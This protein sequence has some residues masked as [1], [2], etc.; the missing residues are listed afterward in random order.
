MFA[1]QFKVYDFKGKTVE[2]VHQEHPYCVN[3]KK[4]MN[5]L[6][7]ILHLGEAFLFW[8]E[9]IKSQATSYEENNVFLEY[10]DRSKPGSRRFG[11]VATMGAFMPLVW[12]FAKYRGSLWKVGAFY[13]FYRFMDAIYDQ[14]I[15][16]YFFLYGPGAMKKVLD[17]DGDKS[18]GH[19]QVKLFMKHCAKLELDKARGDMAKKHFSQ[20]VMI[21]SFRNKAYDTVQL[22]KGFFGDMFGYSRVS[23]VGKGSRRPKED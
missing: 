8:N 17:L 21:R 12:S 23:S 5:H 13:A 7:M 3:P 2:Q 10:L 9:M 1:Y 11:Q 16:L 20:L 19:I 18:F 15:Y 4:S 14:G 22:W 6:F